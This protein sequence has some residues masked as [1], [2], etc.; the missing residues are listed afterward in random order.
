MSENV[1]L[2]VASLCIKLS[3]L[4]YSPPMEYRPNFEAKPLDCI[5][6]KMHGY[7]KCVHIRVT[8]KIFFLLYRIPALDE[9]DR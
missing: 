5:R 1:L 2:M 8:M 3:F 6:G 7:L 9:W 4:P